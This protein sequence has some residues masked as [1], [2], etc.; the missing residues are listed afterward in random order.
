MGS[1]GAVGAVGDLG[2]SGSL[3]SAAAG[4]GAGGV[5]LASLR[6]T[7]RQLH[8]REPLGEESVPV[9]GA[10]VGRLLEAQADVQALRGEREAAQAEVRAVGSQ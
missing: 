6:A 7:L 3:G 2:S 1:A 9:V 4:V 8:I 5:A 10:V